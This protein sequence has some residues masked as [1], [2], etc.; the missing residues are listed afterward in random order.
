M[1]FEIRNGHDYIEEVKH[2]FVEYVQSLGVAANYKEFDGLEEKYKG[3]GEA[4]Y[5][6]F[7]N[8]EPAGCVAIRHVDADTAAMKRLYV[9]PAYRHSS[10]GTSLAEVVVDD[11]R[12]FGYKKLLLDSLPSM[13]NAKQL[14]THLG[15]KKRDTQSRKPVQTVVHMTLPLE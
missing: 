9:R 8:D 1:N 3:P 13:E 6:A 12:N 5:I 2:L 10:L 15:F 14:Y 7:V 4:L 11:A